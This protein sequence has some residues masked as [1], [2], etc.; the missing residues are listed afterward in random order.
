MSALTVAGT[1]AG[2]ARGACEAVPVAWTPAA[3]ETCS[4]ACICIL[5]R[6]AASRFF[7]WSSMWTLRHLQIS[8][9]CVVMNWNAWITLSVPD[10]RIWM[11]EEG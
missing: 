11:Q 8:S 2:R 1:G 5:A 4:T 3:F 6:W 9:P 7:M 10:R